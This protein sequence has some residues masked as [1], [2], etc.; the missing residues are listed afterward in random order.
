[1]PAPKIFIDTNVILYLLSTDAVKADR[2]EGVV[3]AGGC[4]SVQVL[5]EVASVAR[6]RLSMS[7]AEIA[8]LLT[9]IRSLCRI[10]PLTLET[11]DRGL[12]V[13]R[14]HGLNIYDAMIVA[15]ALLVE[16]EILYSEDMQNGLVI[17]DRLRISNPF[18]SGKASYKKGSSAD[19]Q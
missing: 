12:Q 18:F 6:R 9:L 19:Y 14:Q 16:C 1:M 3:A 2:A 8:E 5:N 11:H 4:V 7:W 15:A 10:L 17:E 13:A